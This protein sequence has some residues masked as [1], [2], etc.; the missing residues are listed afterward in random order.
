M[1]D[2]A[3]ETVIAPAVP[4]KAL[5]EIGEARYLGADD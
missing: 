4:L 1:N 3:V 2:S 5:F